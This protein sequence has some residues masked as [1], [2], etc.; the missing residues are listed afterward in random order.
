M[1]GYMADQPSSPGFPGCSKIGCKRTLH[2]NSQ[3]SDHASTKTHAGSRSR[4]T[5]AW[6]GVRLPYGHRLYTAWED[7][8]HFKY[9][10][11]YLDT[12]N[13]SQAQQ[14]PPL[15]QSPNRWVPA[16]PTTADEYEET[17]TLGE[18]NFI[19]QNSEIKTKEI[20]SQQVVGGSNKDKNCKTG[21]IRTYNTI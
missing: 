5:I 4:F 7:A 3:N 18:M 8:P 16:T 10:T 6:S 12:A 13:K 1:V 17:D 2:F 14:S 15:Y 19:F 9:P 20:S 11:V 21:S